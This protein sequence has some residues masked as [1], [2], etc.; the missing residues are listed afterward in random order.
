MRLVGISGSLGKA[1]Y[2]SAILDILIEKA[3]PQAI[4][5]KLDIGS[6]PYYNSD[7]EMTILPKVVTDARALVSL[8]DGVIVVSPEFNHGIPGV[9]KNTLD[10]LSRPAF[11]SCLL[12]KPVFFITQSTGELGGVRAQYQLRETFASMLANVLPLREVALSYVGQK[13]VDGKLVNK[14]TE[15]FLTRTIERVLSEINQLKQVK[16]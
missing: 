8:C 2:S 13:I 10:W 9:L 7:L 6:L 14:D 16:Q 11:N 3:T 1:A 5:E 12:H 4:I 15:A